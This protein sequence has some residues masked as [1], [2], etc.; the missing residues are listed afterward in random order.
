MNPLQ[1]LKALGQSVWLDDIRRRWLVDGTLARLI[2]EDGL[3]GLTSNPA[4]FGRA[5]AHSGD[6]AD[7][8]ARLA[9][10]GVEGEAMI[11]ALAGADVSRAADLFRPLYETSR[12]TDGYVSLEVAPRL[13]YDARG[14]V[15]AAHRLWAAVDRPNVMIKVPATDAG[16]VAIRALLA[17]GV[18]VNVTLLFGLARY[19]QVVDA[20]AAALEQRAACGLALDHV[21]SVASFF[22]SRID[23][24]VDARLDA[25]GGTAAQQLRGQAAIACARLA[26]RYFRD[27]W[28]A[29]VRWRQLAQRG[30]RP[31]RL[32]WASTS[33]KDAAYGDV[34]YVEA[35]IGPGTV[36]TLPYETLEAFRDHG[37]AAVRIEEAL[38][39]ATA[40]PQRLAALGIDL[41][42]A[43]AAMEADGVRRFASAYQT[44]LHTLAQRAVRTA[45][46]PAAGA[47]QR[48]AQRT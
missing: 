14:T 37:R 46:P 35:L 43:A 39:A 15:Q 5:I 29:S 8:I 11:E 24:W 6:Y 36:T 33:T 7:A 32:L 25:L 42:E 3:A 44:L 4:I 2:E 18:N 17:A 1:T 34:R 41:D 19:R 47:A 38:A 10:A 45:E 22:V 40:L 12:G 28:L 30:A 26:Y 16:L 20:H 21:A 27:D 23:T 13:A 48:K 31:Q 9:R